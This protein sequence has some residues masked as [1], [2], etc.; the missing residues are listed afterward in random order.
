MADNRDDELLLLLL[1]R[2]RRQHLQRLHLRAAPRWW[3]R[4]FITLRHEQGAHD[5]L[6]QELRHDQELFFNF[7]RVTPD[8]FDDLLQ[9]IEPHI[10]KENFIRESIPPALRLPLTLR[11]IA[12]GDSMVSLHYLYRV[13]KT[14]VSRIIAETTAAIWNALQPELL[15]E[16][17]Q[18]E[19][20]KVA[21]DFGDRWNFPNCVGAI[22]GKHIVVQCFNN[23]G[24]T[25]YN[26]KGSFSIVLL[27]VC[28]AQYRFT[29]VSIGS[30]G[31]ESDGGI[32]QASDFGRAMIEKTLPLPPP[33]V[34]P[35]SDV[36][37]PSV[38]VGDAAFPQLENLMR[39][40]PGVNLTPDQ[41]IFNY[42]LS[43]ARMCI[44]NAFGVLAARMRIFRKPIIACA[45]TV[46]SIVKCCVVLH[47]W[48]RDIEVQLPP[49]QRRYIPPRY[50]D[51]EDR[52]GHMQRGQWREEV[53]FEGMR[54]LV[55]NAARNSIQVAKNTR[56]SFANYFITEGKVDWQ[57]NKLPEHQREWY[58][59]Q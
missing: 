30:A 8:Q 7:H 46:E 24:S 4:P 5:N 11:Y 39:P 18:G 27:A 28:D 38:F 33:A 23:T 14:T 26:Y 49:G 47:N 29:Y 45:E 55:P 43:R 6:V 37:L 22:D 16:L 13:G 59:R 9:R 44:E 36:C 35:G 31:R 54:N 25:F 20:A 10:S 41:V 34:L 57:W 15:R 56:N 53:G 2:R 52:F 21:E 32:F 48:L 17:N 40:Y 1:L 58:R 12:S 51:V 42:R 50:V 19:W 3:I